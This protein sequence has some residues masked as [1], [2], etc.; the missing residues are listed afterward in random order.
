M[1]DYE[2]RVRFSEVHWFEV[3]VPKSELDVAAGKD[4]AGLSGDT[5]D[6]R[7]EVNELLTTLA[8]DQSGALQEVDGQEVHAI[9]RVRQ[10]R[11]NYHS[12]ERGIWCRF[13]HGTVTREQHESPS[14]GCPAR[15]PEGRTEEVSAC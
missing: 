1:D 15:C 7:P 4:C 5:D 9:R 14:Y 3:T 11:V 2:V 12:D 8:I 6:Y 10:Y 13:S